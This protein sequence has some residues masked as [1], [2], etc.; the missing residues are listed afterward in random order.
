MAIAD[1]PFYTVVAKIVHSNSNKACTK[2]GRQDWQL[3]Y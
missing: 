2:V 1:P 3:Y